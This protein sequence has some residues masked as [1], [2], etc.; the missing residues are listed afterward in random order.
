M[1]PTT[2]SSTKKAT[3]VDTRE[4]VSWTSTVTGEMVFYER[5]YEYDEEGEVL[6]V[7]LRMN[8]QGELVL[9]TKD[10]EDEEDQ[11]LKMAAD[12]SVEEGE[13][14][15]DFTPEANRTADEDHVGVQRLAQEAQMAPKQRCAPARRRQTSKVNKTTPIPANP[16]H[17][18]PFP[19]A[20]V[21]GMVDYMSDLVQHESILDFVVSPLSETVLQ[22]T[23][24][25][26]LSS[27]LRNFRV[28]DL[29]EVNGAG[30]HAMEKEAY[31]LVRP[32][33]VING[34]RVLDPRPT[35]FRP[36]N[37]DY[38]EIVDLGPL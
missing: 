38:K 25:K 21:V 8:E 3:A 34:R 11:D 30:A 18:V 19:S 17:G 23:S 22:S 5:F 16:L 36:S 27:M 2:R 32:S 35:I 15:P 24:Q 26:S 33:K 10:E 14:D 6:F 37:P 9:W 7:Q 1:P 29:S 12:D 13:V 31:D 28:N 20:L 4:I